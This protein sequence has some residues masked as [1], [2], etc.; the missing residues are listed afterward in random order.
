MKIKHLIFPALISLA[1]MTS[2]MKEYECNCN[3]VIVEG[4]PADS[5][6]TTSTTVT[7][8]NKKDAESNCEYLGGTSYSGQVVVEETCTLGKKK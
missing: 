5:T 6:W 7:N 8:N 2:C 4:E 1:F 3:H